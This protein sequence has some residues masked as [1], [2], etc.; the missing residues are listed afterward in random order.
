[1]E[2]LV[3]VERGVQAAGVEDNHRRPKP[4]SA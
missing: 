3:R 2:R 4:S 1:V